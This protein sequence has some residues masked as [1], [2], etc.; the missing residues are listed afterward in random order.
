MRSRDASWMLTLTWADAGLMSPVASDENDQE[1]AGV[2]WW[3]DS[4]RHW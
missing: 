1:D 4:W 2:E 3:M